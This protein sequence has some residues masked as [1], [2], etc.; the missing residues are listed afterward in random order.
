MCRS[1]L[2]LHFFVGLDVLQGTGS[3]EQRNIYVL[4][5]V[6]PRTNALPV[7]SVS[8]SHK[9]AILSKMTMFQCDVVAPVANVRVSYAFHNCGIWYYTTI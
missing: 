4:P 9:M 7:F 8:G 6:P 2:F 1:D 5:L 3:S